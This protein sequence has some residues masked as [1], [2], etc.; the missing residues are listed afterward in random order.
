[1][2]KRG[3]RQ[4]LDENSGIHDKDV[5]ERMREPRAQSSSTLL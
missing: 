2:W 4:L 5:R 3:D 1:V